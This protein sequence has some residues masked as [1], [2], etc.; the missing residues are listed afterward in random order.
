MGN[1]KMKIRKLK[2]L[3]NTVY[4]VCRDDNRINIGSPLCSD[5]VALNVNSFKLTTAM[6]TFKKGREYLVERDNSDLLNCWDVLQSLVDSGEIHA[7][8][9]GDDELENPLSVYAI[10]DNSLIETLTDEYGWPNIDIQGYL[11]HNNAYFKSK[12]KALQSGVYDIEGYI[13]NVDETLKRLKQD[14]EKFE[15]RKKMYLEKRSVMYKLLN[16]TNHQV[17][18]E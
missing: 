14:L 6:D 9:N 7:I 13:E 16:E 18:E 2:E 5:L 17:V 10:R 1:L 12:E 15:K 3:L 4:T 8:I 11:M